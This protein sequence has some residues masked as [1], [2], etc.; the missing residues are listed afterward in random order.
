LILNKLFSKTNKEF[1]QISKKDLDKSKCFSLFNKLQHEIMKFKG[2][3]K[4][5]S[6]HL[7]QLASL[8][9]IIPLQFY[10]Y[11][12]VH[13]E[14][15]TGKFLKNQLSW[16]VEKYNMEEI[17][18]NYLNKIQLLQNIYG[19]NLT[20]NMVE[21]LMCLLGRSKSTKDL[22]YYLPWPET[23]ES[24][25]KLKEITA[26]QLTFRLEVKDIHYISLICKSNNDESVVLSSSMENKIEEIV[27]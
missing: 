12:P 3:G 18:M 1:F 27:L 26:I 23:T 19:K 14:G 13:V 9:G 11:L 4:V 7:I 8:L 16:N 21:N 6:Q 22:Y 17:N 5:K 25:P 10:A 2:I 24:K 15:G 20:P